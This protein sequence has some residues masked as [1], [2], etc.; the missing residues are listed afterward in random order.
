M[1]DGKRG[2]RGRRMAAVL[3]LGLTTGLTLGPATGAFADAG[4]NASCMGHESSA[5]SPPGSS[6]EFPGGRP[7]LKAFIDEA[8]PGVP[9]GAVYREIAK[10]HEVS[11]E[12]CDAALE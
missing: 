11:H 1:T 5:I 3:S 6:G 12:A 8:F 10:L 4:D 9:P 2:V 7:Q